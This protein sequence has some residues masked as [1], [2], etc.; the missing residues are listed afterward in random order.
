MNRETSGTRHRAKGAFTL[1]ELLVVIAI[2]AILAALLLPALTMAKDK[3]MRTICINN[4]K[5]MGVA[6]RMYVDENN[7]HLVWPNW[8]NSNNSTVPGWLYCRTN[9]V[10][11][12]SAG[13]VPNPDNLLWRPPL[14]KAWQTGLWIQ[15][16]NNYKVYL[17]PVDIRS[18][19]YTAKLG[20]SVR[21][22][23][24][25]SYVMNGATCGYPTPESARKYMTCRITAVWNPLCYLLWEPNEYHNGPSSPDPTVYNDGSNYP[26]S[27]EGLAAIHSHKGG[28]MLALDGHGFEFAPPIHDHLA[29]FKSD[30]QGA[31]AGLVQAGDMAAPYFAGVTA[32]EHGKVHPVEPGQSAA[33]PQPQV[34]VAGLNH[35]CQRVLR[36]PILRMPEA[37]EIVRQHRRRRLDLCARDNPPAC[38]PQDQKAG[39]TAMRPLHLRTG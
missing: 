16:L 33:R 29:T 32:V 26:D 36:Q 21:K 19:T 38:R 4:L 27:R 9:S 14:D 11:P 10:T 6:N 3:A 24:L 12:T 1:I 7:D 25:S 5:Q 28:A 20:A 15:Y 18:P 23:K 13:P 8:D 30:P 31:V 39:G 37:G 34:A 17:C 35:G 22:N 2:I